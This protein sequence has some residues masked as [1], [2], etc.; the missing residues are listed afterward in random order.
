MVETKYAVSSTLLERVFSLQRKTRQNST[1]DSPMVRRLHVGCVQSKITV[2]RRQRFRAQSF[3]G[4]VYRRW[5]SNP[6]QPPFWDTGLGD[7]PECRI[8]LIRISITTTTRRSWRRPL[9]KNTTLLSRDLQFCRRR[10]STLTH[11]K[12]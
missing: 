8:F 7:K 6:S 10:H 4:I 5:I 12:K 11:L 1:K 9:R 3:A 2:R